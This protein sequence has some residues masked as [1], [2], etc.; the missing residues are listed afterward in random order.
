MNQNGQVRKPIL[1]AVF[2]TDTPHSNEA[3]N[4]SYNSEY[5][6]Y[7][8][9]HKNRTSGRVCENPRDHNRLEWLKRDQ[10]NW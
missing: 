10:F 1:D 3:E 2:A 8:R 7:D 9:H 4:T 5:C 6:G